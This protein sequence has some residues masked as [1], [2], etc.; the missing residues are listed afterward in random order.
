MLNQAFEYQQSGDL[1]NAE[2]ICHSVLNSNPIDPDALHFLGIINHLNGK[3]KTAIDLI[4]KSIRICPS[5]PI[6]Y[7]S[8]GS[9]FKSNREFQK[10]KQCYQKA[11]SFK[12]ND[13]SALYHIAGIFY[14]EEKFEQALSYYQK[15]IKANPQFPEALNNMAA[16]LNIL[17]RYNEAKNCCNAAIEFKPNYSEAFNNLGNALKSMGNFERAIAWYEKSMAHS[18][19]SAEVLC[20]LGNAYQEI[21][22]IDRA[23]AL[24]EKAIKIDPGYG[25]AFNNLGTALRSKRK[26]REAESQFR[27]SIRL[28]PND[29]E[30]YHNLG[31][32]RY[33]QGD[34]KSAA[35]WYDKALSINPRSVPTRINRGI[36]FQETDASDQALDYFKAAWELDPQNSKTLSLMLHELYQRC[37]WSR[38]KEFNTALDQ[39]TANELARGYR[40]NEMPFLSLIRTTDPMLNFRVA[41]RWSQEISKSIIGNKGSTKFKHIRQNPKKIAIGYLSNNFRNHPTSHLIRDIFDLHDRTRFVINAYSYGIGDDS[42]HREE[43][44]RNCDMFVDLSNSNH[45]DAA[46]RIYEDH[47]DILVDLVGYMR[48]NRLEICAYRPAPVQVRWLGLAGTTG[49]EFFDYLITDRIIT[50]ENES[51]FFSEKFIYMPDTYQVN[52]K[53]L[54][55]S[56]AICSREDFGLP[57]KGFIYCCFCSVYKIDARVFNIWMKILKNVPGSVLWLMKNNSAAVNNL[58]KESDNSGV[59]PKRIVFAEKMT[60]EDHLERLKLADIALDTIAVTGAATTSDALWSGIPVIS[61]KGNHFASRMTASILSAIGLEDLAVQTEYSYQRLAVEIGTNPSKLKEIKK[62]LRINRLE[63]PLFDTQV[64]V[65]NLEKA[66]EEMWKRH[67][68]GKKPDMIRVNEL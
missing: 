24:Y 57:K 28:S 15:A 30:A 23:I 10:A 41:Q 2:L 17:G 8:L 42:L 66:Y 20:N 26:L 38:L 37:D 54:K 36:I 33:D 27:K 13:S 11:L 4:V 67:V 62:R 60:K 64:Y 18:G 22:A 21:G 65:D 51:S 52:S 47:V 58:K 29:S 63:K 31:N 12:P 6:F 55:N 9:L 53:P 25:K 1:L 19:E 46:R 40:P 59:D 3:N 16:T 48:G 45:E 44:K 43:I 68:S 35:L 39:F 32:V 56:N 5:N 34:L 14:T 49:S 50:P 7:S 61:M